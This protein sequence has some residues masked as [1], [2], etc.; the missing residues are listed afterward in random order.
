MS[1]ATRPGPLAGAELARSLFVL[2]KAAAVYSRD[3]EGYR[4]HAAE[5]RD[6]LAAALAEDDEV[7]L[8]PGEESLFLNGRPLDAR[9]L[10]EAA[11]RFLT[12]E[13]TRRGV[14]A[15]VF[16]RGAGERALDALAYAFAGASRD[17]GVDALRA[18]LQK[19]RAVGVAL[20]TASY[21]APG[22]A[23]G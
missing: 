19:E 12:R 4:A 10:G 23:A 1:P 13:L 17:A 16:T 2:F 7:R 22:A 3:N 6:A 5:A 9:G 14:G 15:V 20:L 21:D 8:E 18:A 11:V